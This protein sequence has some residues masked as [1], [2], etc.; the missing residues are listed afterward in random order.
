MND[1]SKTRLK[2]YDIPNHIE[3]VFRKYA[4]DNRISETKIIRYFMKNVYKLLEN[5]TIEE[6]KGVK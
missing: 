6:I 4:F 3:D 2:N 1:L 5:V